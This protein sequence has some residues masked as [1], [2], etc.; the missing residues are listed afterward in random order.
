M[1]DKSCAMAL[2]PMIEMMKFLRGA[3]FLNSQRNIPCQVPSAGFP[4]T[5]GILIVEPDS[6]LLM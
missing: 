4:F 5:I 2:Y 6:T 1:M 3:L